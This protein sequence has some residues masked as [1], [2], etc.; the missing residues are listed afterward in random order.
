[1]TAR[2]AW[3]ADLTLADIP[4]VGGKG[5]NLG[6]LS[7]A[8]F[9]VP[10]GFVVTAAGYTAAMDEAGVRADLMARFTEACATAEDPAALAVAT[11]AVV[12]GL[13]IG[14]IAG[15]AFWVAWGLA[16]VAFPIVAV[17]VLWQRPGP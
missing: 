4:A 13:L 7:R 15:D 9:P 8:G 16:W 1:M 2:I 14:G 17:L 10:P 5:A 3:F 11:A 12:A 6:E